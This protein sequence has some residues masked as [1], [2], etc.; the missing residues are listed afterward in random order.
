MK[1]TKKHTLGTGIEVLVNC[2]HS[3]MRDIALI[4]PN[5]RN[6]NK[7]PTKQIALLAKIIAFDPYA[8]SGSTIF[9][10]EQLKRACY[11]IEF[12]PEYTAVILQRWKDTYGSMPVLG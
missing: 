3:E 5:P 12:K 10:A 7:H 1:N 8:G 6:P 2:A 9:A 11:A 4:V